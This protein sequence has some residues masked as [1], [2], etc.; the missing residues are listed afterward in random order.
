MARPEL[1]ILVPGQGTGFA[2]ELSSLEGMRET[3]DEIQT[4]LGNHPH[5]AWELLNQPAAERPVSVLTAHLLLTAVAGH[6]AKL[7]HE[8]SPGAIVT[9]SGHSA[10]LPASLSFTNFYK[11]GTVGMAQVMDE[12]A[13][14]L[15]RA[16]EMN[17]GEMYAVSQ[18]DASVIEKVISWVKVRSE[19]RESTKEKVD[20]WVACI[21]YLSVAGGQ[22]VITARSGGSVEELL[23]KEFGVGLKRGIKKLSIAVGAHSPLVQEAAAEFWGFFLT[24]QYWFQNLV[25]EG[26][27][28][29]SDHGRNERVPPIASRQAVDVYLELSSLNQ[30]VTFQDAVLTM[31]K[32]L[33][34][35][36]FWE[37]GSHI[38]TDMIRQMPLPAGIG[39]RALTT[40]ADFETATRLLA[41]RGE[42]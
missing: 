33:G 34:V 38:L 25:G 9:V 20:V 24:H 2:R 27:K 8:F 16:Q 36:E 23:V 39:L 37:I 11:E 3:C 30:R 26:P 32:D 28:F 41:N 12:R 13:K 29:V 22:V 7:F 5:D 18:R 15:L 40:P 42:V 21:N 31:V 1:G 35:R 19:E 10:G 4:A 17:P 14:R 6:A